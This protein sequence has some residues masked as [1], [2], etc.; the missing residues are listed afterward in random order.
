MIRP[1]D[2]QGRGW[3]TGVPQDWKLAYAEEVIRNTYSD[4]VSVW[5]KKKALN[6]FGRT[7][8][9]DS[10]VSTTVAVFQGTVVNETY[11]STNIIDSIV[12]SN[13]GDTT[14]TITVEGHTI[15]GSGN[16]TF[17]TQNASLNGQTEVT[18][19]TPLARANRAFVANS[20]TFDSPY[21]A[22]AGTISIY[23]NTGGITSG[24]PN[25]AAATKLIID[26][27]KTQTEKCATSISS[28][29]YWIITALQASIEERGPTA[30]ADFQIEIR[31]V[32][33]GGVWRPLGAEISLNSAGQSTAIVKFDPYRIVPKSHDVRVV[34]ISNTANTLCSAEIEG[35]LA[36]VV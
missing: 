31:D 35:Y 22:L 4:T 25:T 13:T 32:A 1:Q 10:G 14:Q 34:V 29:D 33:N 9:A 11:V 12:S 6:K 30:A 2:L 5:E 16:L 24:V 36:S 26:A 8:N 20:T 19:S 27:G 18:L 21:A 17:V 7:S 23:D 15:D 28:Q 3:G